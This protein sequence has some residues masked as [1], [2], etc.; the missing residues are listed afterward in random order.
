VEVNSGTNLVFG[1]VDQKRVASAQ[2]ALVDQII[3]GQIPAPAVLVGAD[4]RDVAVALE[5]RVL[6]GDADDGDRAQRAVPLDLPGVA[7]VLEADLA[8]DGVRALRDW[9]AVQREAVA[10]DED[11]LGAVVGVPGVR[12][13]AHLVAVRLDGG[14]EVAG[15]DA[16]RQHLVAVVAPQRL[17]VQKA[18]P[19][20]ADESAASE[21]GQTQVREEQVEDFVGEVRDYVVPLRLSHDAEAQWRRSFATSRAGFGSRRTCTLAAQSCPCVAQTSFRFHR[22]RIDRDFLNSEGGFLGHTIG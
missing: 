12:V 6:G 1:R 5:R 22:M 16:G 2:L 10:L 13:G 18:V 17:A 4:E 8:A 19:A 11:V 7:A 15:E 20:A 21:V 3:F 9:V 14:E